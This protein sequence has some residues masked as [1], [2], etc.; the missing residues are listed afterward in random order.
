MRV[1]VRARTYIN[2]RLHKQDNLKVHNTILRNIPD[3]SDVIIY[4]K[5]YINK[6]DVRTD[7]KV[8]RSMIDNVAM[9]E[10]YVSEARRKIDTIH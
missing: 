6:D 7:V 1:C 2:L 9:Q 3:A 10:H 4:V 5:P 8:L